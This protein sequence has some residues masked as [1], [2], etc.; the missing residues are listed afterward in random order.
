MN[1][2]V[3]HPYTA[4]V[5]AMLQA[6]APLDFPMGDLE[7][8]H[9]AGD[10]HFAVAESDGEAAAAVAWRVSGDLLEIIGLNAEG[11]ALAIRALWAALQERRRA[12]GLRAIMCMVEVRKMQMIVA[13]LGMSPRAVM[14]VE[15]V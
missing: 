11:H 12:D 3:D 6:T 4:E 5:A 14:Y 1:V 15:A 8:Q 2:N 9:S 13:H 7:A 10:V